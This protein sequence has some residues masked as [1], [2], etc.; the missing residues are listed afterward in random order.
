MTYKVIVVGGGITGLCVVYELTKVLPPGQ[1]ILIEKE[2]RLG[3]VILTEEEKGLL[4]EGGPDCL[5]AEKPWAIELAKEIG[6]GWALISPQEAFKGTYILWKKKLRKLPEGFLLLVPRDLVAFLK[7]DLLTPWGKIRVLLE[8]FVPPKRSNEDEDLASFVRRRLGKEVLER[9]VD[10]LIGGVHG[11]SA[12]ELSA[13][14]VLPRFVE[15][16]KRWGS[17]F[18]GIR[19]F[20]MGSKGASPFLSFKKGMGQLVDA[21]VERLRGVDFVLGERVFY[22]ET[23]KGAFRVHTERGFY[24]AER[25]VLAVPAG[26]AKEI[27][28][29]TRPDCFSLLGRFS[30]VPTV[31]L[32]VAWKEEEVSGIKGY[33]FVVSPKEG[34]RLKAVSFS[35]RK[36]EDRAPKG[37][38]LM[39]L[40]LSHVED[41][42]GFDDQAVFELALKELRGILRVRGAPLFWRVYRWPQGLAQIKRGHLE[43]VADLRKALV[44]EAKGVFVVGSSYDGIGISDCVRGARAVAMELLGELSGQGGF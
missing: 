4:L 8:P 22:V 31:V 36:F 44:K 27:L 18:K 11:T 19:R 15:M 24:E 14:A 6:L 3:G 2:R 17:L 10:P 12:S 29:P 21:L 40:F 32:N 25:V 37:T 26:Q 20:K 16:E 43:L 9:I 7:T 28:G 13:K 23:L 33:G 39:R 5:Y 34:L 30:S 35:S 42:L 41:L 38:L 1:V